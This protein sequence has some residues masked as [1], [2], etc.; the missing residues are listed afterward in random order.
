[1]TWGMAALSDLMS[2]VLARMGTYE[3]KL[4]TQELAASTSFANHF[5]SLL[6]A[7]NPVKAIGNDAMKAI[8]NEF[9]PRDYPETRGRWEILRR[10]I[11]NVVGHYRSTLMD[12]IN[13]LTPSERQRLIAS[14]AAGDFSAIGL[15]D[16]AAPD[17]LTSLVNTL[18]SSLTTLYGAKLQG[19]AAKDIAKINAQSA[20]NTAAA[21]QQAAQMQQQ[22][23]AAQAAMYGGAAGGGSSSAPGSIGGIPT[24]AVATGGV[25]LVGL[26]LLM[27]L[28]K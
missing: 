4:I 18:G 28:K 2:D 15:S 19:D 3:Q 13:N 16:A 1:M 8:A 6:H 25:G 5:A 20:Q 11:R 26:I 9:N 10:T 22:M 17:F 24:W 7:S 14:I 23:A 21:A 12:S 27:L